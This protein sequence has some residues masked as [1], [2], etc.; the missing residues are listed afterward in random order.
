MRHPAALFAA[1]LTLA[2]FAPAA[3]A[4]A[5]LTEFDT[6]SQVVNYAQSSL[7]D[8]SYP[9]YVSSFDGWLDARSPYRDPALDVDE[10]GDTTKDV[11]GGDDDVVIE[12]SETAES[13]APASGGKEDD[14]SGTNNKEADVDE[15]DVVKNDGRRLY[16]FAGDTLRVYNGRADVPILIGTREL[17]IADAT[18]LR[19]G[20]KLLAIG[21]RPA[22]RRA[23]DPDSDYTGTARS[24]AYPN[25][26]RVIELDIS[27]PEQ[28]R[29]LRTLDSPGR[30]ITARQVGSTVRIV[31]DSEP[32]ID[33]DD[34]ADA[35][36]EE[37]ADVEDGLDLRD[38]VPTTTLR[39][40]VTGAIYKRPMAGCDDI[41]HPTGGSAGV[42]LLSVFTVDM[43]KGLV[44]IDRQGVLASPQVV[45]A[46]AGTLYVGSARS[47][48]WWDRPAYDSYDECMDEEYIEDDPTE[49][50]AETIQYCSEFKNVVQAL[51]PDSYT[52]IYAFDTTTPG[53]TTYAGSGRVRGLPIN[54]YAFSEY[55]GD[56][57]V[58]TTTDPWWLTWDEDD[59]PSRADNRVT[60]LRRSGAGGLGQI[61]LLTGIGPTEEIDA[62]RFFGERGYIAT[63]RETAP[64]FTIDLSN[65][66]QPMLTGELRLSSTS[67]YLHP[68]GDD[69]LLGIGRERGN[70]ARG[71]QVSLYDVSDPSHPRRLAQRILGDGSATTGY[72]PHAFL[73]WPR[74][75]MALVPFWGWSYYDDYGDTPKDA[76]PAALVAL[77]AQA[78]EG[79]NLTELGRVIHGPEWDHPIPDRAVVMGDRLF[80]ISDLGIA[81]NRVDDLTPLGYVP[82]LYGWEVTGWPTPVAPTTPTATTPV[83]TTPTTPPTTPAATSPTTPV[84][85]SPVSPSTPP[86]Q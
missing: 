65:P 43:D 42:E 8:G 12:Q 29:V 61:G 38:L 73:W 63:S 54:Q 64:L 30:L 5:E 15:P 79:P 84:A 17:P 21:Q 32:D 14:A 20:D 52:D 57:R 85:T 1:T 37:Q 23:R 80:S 58:A 55:Q 11:Y 78:G 33:L 86:K 7:D 66:A 4:L 70:G 60:V 31:V 27:E 68:L 69:L 9:E 74:K 47:T 81:S 3:P 59:A 13:A 35:S 24:A 26:V 34:Y 45:Y 44:G 22:K 51:P 6:C 40:A 18:L 49:D 19:S 67:A 62:V 39:S 28:P 50:K 56:L 77:R 83:G 71:A 36:D 25:S 10:G 72:D 53:Q 82:F 46:S 16:L 41:S 48:G 76:D 2:A 75:K